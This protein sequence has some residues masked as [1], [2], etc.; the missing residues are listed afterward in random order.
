MNKKIKKLPLYNKKCKEC[1][2][3]IDNDVPMFHTRE[4]VYQFLA[5]KINEIIDNLS[6]K[7]K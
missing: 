7:S 5:K 6:L 3:E 4:Q 2:A 1:G